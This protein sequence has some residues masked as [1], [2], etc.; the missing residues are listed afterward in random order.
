MNDPAVESTQVCQ[1]EMVE[2][3]WYMSP[4]RVLPIR[5]FAL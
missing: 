2:N 4:D 3:D 1:L 5:A